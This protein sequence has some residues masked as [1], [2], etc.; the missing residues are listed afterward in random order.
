MRAQQVVSLDGPAG[1]RMAEVPEP[2]AAD[3]VVIEVAAAGVSFPDLLLSRGLYQLKPPLPFVPGLEVAGIVRSAPP[4]CGV[5]PGQRVAAVVGMGGFAEVAAAPPASVLPVP[6]QLDL[7]QAAGLILN[8]HTAHFALARRGRL[9]QGETVAVQGAAGGVGTAAVQVG[10]G[11]GARVIALVSSAGKAEVARR[12][13]AEEVVDAQGEWDVE[14]RR[15]TG[16]R[17]ADVIL[18]PVGGDRFDR[19]LRCLAPEGRL[20][21]VGFAEGRIPSVTANRLLLRNIEVVGVAWGAFLA[22]RPELLGVAAT[23]LQ[24]MI[25]SGVVRPL[26]EAVIPFERATEALLLLEQRR[27]LG[28][29]VLALP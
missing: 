3:R 20:L 17:G 7:Q 9:K 14:L 4:E 25:A 21:T 29:I 8:Y 5:T 23:A 12:A 11:L 24:P 19:S 26:I 13:G 15:L 22:A 1:L 10:R 2:D 18:D 6:E 28:K 27:A 16:G